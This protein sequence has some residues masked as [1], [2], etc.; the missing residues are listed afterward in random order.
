GRVLEAYRAVGT[1]RRSSPWQQQQA[2]QELAKLDGP[3]RA[4]AAAIFLDAA[5]DPTADA[6]TRREAA[7]E[8]AKLGHGPRDE[9]IRYLRG[10]ATAPGA[11][12]DDRTYAALQLAE[13]DPQSAAGALAEVLADP[14]YPLADRI[15]AAQQRA[16]F[17]RTHAAAILDGVDAV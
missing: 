5:L 8:W 13:H 7:A 11:D 10:L 14:L 2:A 9:L 4:Q 3:D 12:A 1:D 15:R 16:R 6:W 17:G